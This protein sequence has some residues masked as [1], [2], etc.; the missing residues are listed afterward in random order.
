MSASQFEPESVALIDTG[1]TPEIFASRMEVHTEDDCISLRWYRDKHD[2]HHN[3]A[4]ARVLVAE[5][6]VSHAVAAVLGRQF[7]TLRVVS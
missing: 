6:I 3:N 4:R 2:P 7:N 5:I 1:Q